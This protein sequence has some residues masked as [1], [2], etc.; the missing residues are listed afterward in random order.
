MTSYSWTENEEHDIPSQIF[1]TI[2]GCMP[3]LL[4]TQYVWFLAH[5]YLSLISGQFAGLIIY[6]IPL[7]YIC[8]VTK[9]NWRAM[10]YIQ[11]VL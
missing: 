7:E 10:Y 8:V 1:K 5:L 2:S 3:Q 4:L 11:H 9:S 6:I